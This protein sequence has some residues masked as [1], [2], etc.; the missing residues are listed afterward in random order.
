[1]IIN[2]KYIIAI[3]LNVILIEAYCQMNLSNHSPIIIKTPTLDTLEVG[4]KSMLMSVLWINDT[5]NVRVLNQDIKA[6]S[7][8]I[9]KS[10]KKGYLVSRGFILSDETTIQNCYC[11]ALEKYFENSKT[12]GQSILKKTTNINRESIEKILNNSF[13]K[14]SEFTT[15]PRKNLKN[16]IPNDV[17]LAFINKRDWTTH[18]VYYRDE[19]FYTKNG[20]FEPDEF[21]SLNK[22]LK[23]T[24][25]DTEKIIVYKFDESKLKNTYNN[26]KDLQ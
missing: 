20:M 3:F 11:Y 15:K 12:Y 8:A 26:L 22:F 4:K 16:A 6:N 2:K 21:K 14:I 25:W 7:S 17:I 1:M 24:Y 18:A 23:K 9:K 10:N 19:V 5:I 13:V